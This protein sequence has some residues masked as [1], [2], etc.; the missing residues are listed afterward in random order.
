MGI[1]ETFAWLVFDG[2][3]V[4]K[5]VS[6][7]SLL[8]GI[9]LVLQCQRAE[10][11]KSPIAGIYTRRLGLLAI[12]GILHGCLL[13]A[14]DILFVYACTGCLLF[15]FRKCSAGI[16]FSMA[17]VPLV[18]GISLTLGWIVLG[19]DQWP[20][21]PDAFEQRAEAARRTGG[22]IEVLAIRR[23]EYLMWLVIS[24][25][26]SFNWRVVSLFFL[27]AAI[28]KKGWIQPRYHSLHKRAAWF[29]LVVGG[30]LEVGAA[31]VVLLADQPSVCRSPGVGNL[32]RNRLPCF[33]C[34]LRGSHPVDGQLGPA[35]DGPAR[36]G[37][38]GKN[39]AQ[40]LHTA[41]GADELDIHGLWT[42]NVREAQP[43]GSVGLDIG[44]LLCPD[45]R[46]RSLA[47][48]IPPGTVGMGMAKVDLP[49]VSA[50]FAAS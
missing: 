1:S 20:T 6:L 44:R 23:W 10:E 24:S 17:L 36:L 19:F 45:L 22:L 8:F 46:Q 3:M 30:G 14:G 49:E 33:K 11:K 42:G 15:L 35:R 28:M 25:V 5:F 39:G 31:A 41:I 9:G 32:R 2:L 26:S 16:L 43:R 37:G 21:E 29:G 48:G 40:Q 38:G 34:R 7:F 18:I 4:M 50:H 13:F 12:M 27:G 47:A